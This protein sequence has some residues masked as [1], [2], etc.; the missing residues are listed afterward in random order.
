V[1]VLGDSE[2]IAANPPQC[3][4]TVP[5]HPFL[6]LVVAGRHKGNMLSPEWREVS[7]GPFTGEFEVHFD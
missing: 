5:F 7:G 4:R 3:D 1:P 6:R 2:I